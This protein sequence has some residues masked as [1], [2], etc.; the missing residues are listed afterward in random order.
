MSQSRDGAEAGINSVAN[1]IV[2]T[3]TSPGG[4]GDPITNATYTTTASPVTYGGNPV[5]L[6]T[7]S[8]HTSNYPVSSVATAFDTSGVG[9]GSL[10]AGNLT[11]N[12]NTEATL[13]SMHSAFYPFGSNTK[14]TVQTWK[15]VSD[16][17]ISTI[18][19]AKVEVSAILERHLTPT[20][21]YAAFATNNGCAALT[22][23]G[24]GSTNSYDSS[25]YVSGSGTPA[26]TTTDG[27]IGTNG[28]LST[29]G[30]P[31]TI[32]GDLFT[33]RVGV[34]SCSVS[35]VTAW[36]DSSGTINGSIVELPQAINY[37]T[38]AAPNPVP[39][40]TNTTLNNK[41]T[42]CGTINGCTYGS[43]V[44]GDFYLAPGAC[45]P[46]PAGPGVYDNITI[47]GNVHLSTAAAGTKAC[48]NINSLT[49]NGGGTLII[50]SGPV[51]VNLAGVGVS[52]PLD[53]T[54]GGM[55]NSVTPAYNATSFQILYGG[56]GTIKLKGGGQSIG[57]MYAPN[58]SYSIG[59]GA[60]WYGSLIGGTL[61]DMGGS[62]IHYD[63][64][65]ASGGY[66]VGN[67]M[68]DSFTWKKY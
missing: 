63:K 41:G 24:G 51:I 21:N 34:G 32:N 68:L 54:G 5:V 61:T 10:T 9:M 46:L 11:I 39:G 66:T 25:T 12:Y 7:I 36:T 23:G 35:N 16:G 40:T 55:I 1:Y 60:D 64:H 49:E 13:L 30:S 3:Y 29:I 47:K 67:W 43:P 8:G 52:I 20:F 2:N 59:G 4:P 28:N 50:D 44:A 45:P 57:V 14:Q 15:I 65:L 56:T 58:A 27:N 31:T 62:A 6:T 17:S 38:P 26:F 42:D 19:N 22:F 37:P 48:Y 18:R 33:P 53:I